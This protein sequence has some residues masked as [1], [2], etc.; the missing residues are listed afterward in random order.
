MKPNYKLISRVIPKFI[1]KLFNQDLRI[2]DSKMNVD[3]FLGLVLFIISSISI[4]TFFITTVYPLITTALV[5]IFTWILVYVF[6]NFLTYKKTKEIELTLPDFL[7]LSSSNIRA[8]MSIDRA[9]WFSIRSNFGALADEMETIAKKVLSGEDFSKALEEFGEK[10]DSVLIKRAVKLIIEGLKSGGEMADLLDKLSENIRG[11]HTIQ[12]EISANVTTY[13]IFI[14]FAV[15][16]SAPFLFALGYQLLTVMENISAH[17]V[18]PAS[19]STVSPISFR[20]PPVTSSQF[21][22]FAVIWLSVSSIFSSML[23]SSIKKGSIKETPSVMVYLLPISVIVFLVSIKM[24]S[25]FFSTI[26][27]M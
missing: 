12:K 25:S 19:M 22:L 27:P 20:A 23:I 21:K 15:G 17:V 18:L 26:I 4:L 6:F 8:G 3:E 7:Q 16:V 24:L 9:F 5:F 10:F 11:M 13:V 14:T 1:K 2:I